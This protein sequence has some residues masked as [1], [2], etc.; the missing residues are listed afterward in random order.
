[1]A[2]PPKTTASP[3][4]TAAQV[5]SDAPVHVQ[6]PFQSEEMRTRD[7]S[8]T[9][10]HPLY[11]QTYHSHHGAI[12]ESKH[13][14]LDHGELAARLQQ[15][16]VRLLEIGIGT[17]L[18]LI[19]SATLAQRMN[20]EMHY[21][22]IE[23]FPPSKAALLNLGYDQ[24]PDVDATLWQECVEGFDQRA[25][26]WKIH[27]PN[28]GPTSSIT[29]HWGRFEDIELPAQHFDLVYH[30]AFSPDVNPECWT[31]D[32]L[33][34]IVRSMAPGASLVTYTVQGDVRRALAACGLEVERLPGPTNG[35]KQ[36]LRARK[37]TVA[38]N[39]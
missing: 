36:V 18:N 38:S 20:R 30:D 32:A 7:G 8:S 15:G 27:A 28:D 12:T 11:A 23:Q 25:P 19:L 37:S 34:K 24:D 31:P 1:M 33:T 14:F 39:T 35:K 6:A 26:Q 22:G 4:A 5:S 3:N 2:Q 17:G 29:C 10:F 21:V 13:V 9:L 16:P